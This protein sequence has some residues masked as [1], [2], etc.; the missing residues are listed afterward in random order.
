MPPKSKRASAQHSAGQEES[1]R[2]DASEEMSD[3]ELE[4]DEDEEEAIL[5]FGRTREAARERV[6]P[7]TRHQY[8]LFMGLMARFFI[9]IGRWTFYTVQQKYRFHFIS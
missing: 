6:A 3:P 4:I 8:D 7:R 9:S 1:D 2:S 5:N